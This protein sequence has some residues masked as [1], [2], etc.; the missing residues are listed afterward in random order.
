MVDLLDWNRFH[1]VYFRYR[2]AS[3]WVVVDKTSLNKKIIGTIGAH[4][5]QPEI[6]G[7]ENT[8]SNVGIQLRV[9]LK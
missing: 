9:R 4:F 1:E 8:F 3:F 6:F 2:L 5:P 7:V